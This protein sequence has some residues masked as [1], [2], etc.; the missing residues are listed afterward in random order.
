MKLTVF[1]DY[2]LRVLVYLASRPGH[3]ATV[4]EIAG[5]F[6]VKVN[7]LAKVVH[8]LGRCGWHFG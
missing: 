2:G 3:R 8:H 1:T 6:G 4:A 7:H 5:A